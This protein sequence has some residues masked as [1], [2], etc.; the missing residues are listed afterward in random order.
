MNDQHGGL[1][2]RELISKGAAVSGAAAVVGAI[3]GPAAVSALSRVPYANPHA[4]PEALGAALPGSSYFNI[5]A[6][7]F[8]PDRAQDRVYQDL[9]GSQPLTSGK[10]IWAPLP[11]VA[12]SIITQISA[13]YQGQPII[14]IS[15]RPLFSGQTATAPAQVFQQTLPAGG[16]GPFASTLTVPNL[17][18]DRTAT[19]TVSAY[20]LPGD[21]ILG[22]SIGHLTGF[23]PFTGPTPRVLDS[24]TNGGPISPDTD[25]L[26]TLGVPGRAAVFNLT[27]A[28]PSGAGYLAAFR[29]DIDWPGNS[30]VNFG[31]AGQ[32]A[33]NLVIC[34]MNTSGEIKL[35]AGVSSTNV[36][37]DLV[38]SMI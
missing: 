36:V 3:G 33:A 5:D 17:V 16:G 34:E 37:V 7:G 11:L 29:A 8:F 18:I 21:S 26:V 35:R 9:T 2:R 4:F 14:E 20:C 1:S 12:G 25:R 28:S 15:R 27:A 31:G 23:V 32:T 30:S 24:R 6:Y 38:G 10:R 22:V 13:S 19:Y